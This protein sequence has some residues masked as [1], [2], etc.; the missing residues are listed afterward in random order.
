MSDYI[1][2]VSFSNQGK[3]QYF[4]S[5][6]EVNNNELVVCESLRGIEL[7]RIVSSPKEYEI[8]EGQEIP[9]SYILRIAT[10]EDIKIYEKNKIES[11]EAIKIVQQQADELSLGMKV[12]SG[13]YT[14]DRTKLII[15]YLADD[16]VDFRELLKVLASLYHCRIELKQIGP[17]DKAKMIGGIGICGLPLCCSTFLNE[18]DGISITMAKNQMLALNIPKLSGHCG[19]LICCLKYEDEAYTLEKK[20][21]PRV[22]LRIY[23]N[24]GIYRI[25]SINII[26]KMVRLEGQDNIVN[27]PLSA[28]ENCQTVNPNQPQVQPEKKEVKPIIEQEEKQENVEVETSQQKDENN[29]PR[30][31]NNFKNRHNHK[32]NFRHFKKGPRNE[33]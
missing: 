13:E 6:Y 25:T 22:G 33:A 20:D 5:N 31:N 30:H 28:I 11:L 14:L 8:I 10:E 12:T 17:R 16:R 15:S 1:F 4:L 9:F 24:D 29:K 18:F 3:P 21:L 32:G 19:K 23:Y 27:V 2:A 7:G 26:T